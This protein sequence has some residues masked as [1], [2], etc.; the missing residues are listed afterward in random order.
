M[1]S[2][3]STAAFLAIHNGHAQ[4]S[5]V[6]PAVGLLPAN[7][8]RGVLAGGM[9]LAILAPASVGAENLRHFGPGHF[10]R[11]AIKMRSAAGADQIQGRDPHRVGWPGHYRGLGVLFRIAADCVHVMN[12][13]LPGT[14]GRTMLA[15][16]GF[17]LSYLKRCG[18]LLADQLNPD[19]SRVHARPVGRGVTRP[20][21]ELT[22]V[23]SPKGADPKRIAARGACDFWHAATIPPFA[24]AGTTLLVADR[25]QRDAIGIELNPDYCAL[26]RK[27]LAA[28][29]PLLTDVA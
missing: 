8:E 9:R 20:R 24:G 23:G 15:P 7:P 12:A 16:M 27:R 3:I 10:P 25:L 4:A 26:I 18:A 21:A 19:R 11:L 14:A 13:A 6:S 17:G 29:A 2:A 28:D 22:A 1:L 5:P